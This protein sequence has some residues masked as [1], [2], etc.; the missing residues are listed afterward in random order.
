MLI[1]YLQRHSAQC[2]N[3]RGDRHACQTA[4]ASEGNISNAG[5]AVRDGHARQTT[6]A[7]E[8]SIPNAGDR[9]SLI[10]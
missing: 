1:L 6:A 8:G 5:D 10:G 3:T 9:F 7:L 4:A 2:W